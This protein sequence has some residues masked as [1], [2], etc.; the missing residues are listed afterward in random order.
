MYKLLIADDEPLVRKGI[1]SLVP[2]DKLGIG[3]VLEASDG[4]EA[5]AI[6]SK[7]RPQIILADINMPRMNGLDMARAMKE[8]DPDVQIAIITGYDYFDYAVTAIKAGV[9][10]FILKPVSQADI[11]ALLKK[12]VERLKEKARFKEI[13]A[14]VD[15][16]DAG[17]KED[18]TGYRKQM[19]QLMETGIGDSSFSLT[20]M[21]GAMGLSPGYAGSLFKD[22]FGEPFQDRLLRLRLERAK[23]LLLSSEMKNYEVAEKVG[24]DD[25][26]YFATRFKKTFG[27]TPSQFRKR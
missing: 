1:V 14:A 11:S 27:C 22:L 21:A 20:A 26:G 3:E 19:Q 24:F 18:E 4:Q 6:F 5:L 9:D 15:Q 8:E 17:A 10:D 7:H 25:P 23:V 13:A 12:L 16:L 2:F